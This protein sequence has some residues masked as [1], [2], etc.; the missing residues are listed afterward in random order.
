MKVCIDNNKLLLP[1]PSLFKLHPFKT[2]TLHHFKQTNSH[3]NTYICSSMSENIAYM[4]QNIDP[5]F[6]AYIFKN[7]FGEVFLQSNK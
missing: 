2:N 7:R 6:L 3:L 5:N 4:I 1:F